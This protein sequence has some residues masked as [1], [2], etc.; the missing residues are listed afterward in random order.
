MHFDGK[1]M[2]IAINKTIMPHIVN[3]GEYWY[4][5]YDKPLCANLL[6]FQYHLETHNDMLWWRKVI[7]YFVMQYHV[8]H[9]DQY[10]ICKPLYCEASIY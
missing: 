7:S 1:H 6:E 5:S 4:V 2:K 3:V 10:R 9:N 8:E